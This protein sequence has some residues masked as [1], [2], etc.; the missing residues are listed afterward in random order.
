MKRKMY[1]LGIVVMTAVYVMGCGNRNNTVDAD[2]GMTREASLEKESVKEAPTKQ[3]EQEGTETTE[4]DITN[5]Q[6]KETTSIEETVSTEEASIQND[7]FET[8]LSD[9]NKRKECL[10]QYEGLTGTDILTYGYEGDTFGLLPGIMKMALRC[11]NIINDL[12]DEVPPEIQETYL[13][14]MTFIITGGYD[15][16]TGYAGIFSASALTKGDDILPVK[17]TGIAVQAIEKYEQFVNMYE[18]DEVVSKTCT[19]E[20][21]KEYLDKINQEYGVINGS[22]KNYYAQL[23]DTIKYQMHWTEE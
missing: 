7:E 9:W 8:L 14:I 21:I 3:A 20:T 18:D 12:N 23:Q 6:E 11:E 19:Y 13:E 1:L 17:T 4:E 10:A 15:E 2:Q 5:M 16:E 22:I